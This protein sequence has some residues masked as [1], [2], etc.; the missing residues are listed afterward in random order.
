MKLYKKLSLPLSIAPTDTTKF[1][2]NSYTSIIKYES[3]DEVKIILFFIRIDPFMK[4]L[5]AA[6]SFIGKILLSHILQI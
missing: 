5:H 3:G 6:I 1:S 2:A 4:I